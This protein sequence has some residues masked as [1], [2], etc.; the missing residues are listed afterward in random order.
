VWSNL[1]LALRD[2]GQL[3]EA[4][5]ACERALT[6]DPNHPDALNHLGTVLEMH[7][8]LQESLACYRRAVAAAPQSPVAHLNLGYAHLRLGDYA[9]GWRENEWRFQ[10][11]TTLRR[12]FTQ[13]RWDGDKLHGRRILVHAEQGFGDTIQFARYVPLLA[14]RCGAD[15]VL[16][17]CHPPLERLFRGSLGGAGGIGAIIP[18]GSPLPPFDVHCPLMSLPLAL[19]ITRAEDANA[20]YLA[21]D[22]DLTNAWRRRLDQGQSPNR[23]KIGLCWHGRPT[24]KH[25]RERSLPLALL[26]PLI[27]TR[28]DATFYSLQKGDAAR[29][30][31]NA[32]FRLIDCT[33]E[34]SDFAD[35]AACISALDL[36]I[37]IDTSVAH[38]AG[39]LGRPVWMMLSL[40]REWRWRSDTDSSPWYPSMRIFLQQTSGDWQELIQRVVAYLKNFTPEGTG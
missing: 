15:H 36:V 20:P 3:R 30:L 9:N 40:L 18:R 8:R 19:G 29:E 21:A 13:P 16:L 5:Q 39:A 11:N 7:G 26:A 31:N 33:T 32:P 4:Q 34:F 24:Y 17:E 1:A 37:T 38:L 10:W 23:L 2:A 28:N 25:N 35:T 6:L 27:A 22:Q 12:N 14:Q